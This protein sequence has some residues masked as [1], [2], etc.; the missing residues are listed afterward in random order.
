M[1]VLTSELTSATLDWAVAKCEGATDEWRSDG[2]FMWD[3]QVPAIRVGRHSLLTDIL[4]TI[5]S[6]LNRISK[7]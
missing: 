5:H 2:P 1:K 4:G 7:P 6:C 3:G